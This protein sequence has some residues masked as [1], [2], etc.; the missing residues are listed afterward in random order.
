MKAVSFVVLSLCVAVASHAA[1]RLDPVEYKAGDMTLR[2]FVA[3]DDAVTARRPGVVVV[4]QWWGLDDNAKTRA[5]MLAEAG[6][7]AFA[8]DMYGDGKVTEHPQEAGEWASA[9]GKNKQVAGERFNAAVEQ[10]KKN[11]RVDPAHICAVGYCF[12]GSIVLGAAMGGA[13]LDGVVSFHG[14]LPADP[15]TGKVTASI[16]VCH[17]AADGF[18]SPELIQ[19]FQKNLAAANADWEFISYG[20]AKHA[21]TDPTADKR[22]IPGLAYDEKADK[23]SWKTALDFL[24]EV[25]K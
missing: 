19:T 5:K 1:V 3:Y 10:L 9:V 8:A 24:A 7:V 15:A 20:N 23:R 16:L 22:G 4:H 25:T 13:D 2:G 18:A 6:Y 12:G 21:F 11:P 14:G 17:G